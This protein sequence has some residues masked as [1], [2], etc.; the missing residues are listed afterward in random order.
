MENK[1]NMQLS[2]AAKWTDTCIYSDFGRVK[3]ARARDYDGNMDGPM[4]LL[5]G[6]EGSI[7]LILN[8]SRYLI[9]STDAN[10]DVVLFHPV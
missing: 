1:E 2:C 3:Q 6:V 10:H 8:H 9:V 7:W 5:M 4:D